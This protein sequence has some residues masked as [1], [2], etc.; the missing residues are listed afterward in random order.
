VTVEEDAGRLVAET[1]LPA[2]EDLAVTATAYLRRRRRAR[3]GGLLLGLAFGLAPAAGDDEFN[4]T[5]GRWLVGFLLGLLASELLVRQRPR[6]QRRAASLHRRSTRD[7]IPFGA[8]LL[9]WLTLV[10]L[11]ATPLLALGTHPRGR[12]S[13]GTPGGDSCEASAYWPSTGELIAAG[14]IAVAALVAT[15][16]I[17]RRLVDRP[18]PAD[19]PDAWTLDHELRARSARAAV[20]AASAMGLAMTSN[21]I[22]AV[23]DG[24]HSFVCPGGAAGFNGI[25]NVYSWAPSVTPWLNK[26]TA[27]LLLGALVTW[28]ICHLLPTPRTQAVPS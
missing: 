26:V 13:T 1:G 20:A 23:N 21:V 22:Q 25:S 7:L 6:Q 28:L 4:L 27:P 2:R 24:A 18:Q 9:P 19:D 12:T 11:M 14:V 5:L 8:R 15:E 10:P 16:L 17:L 3:V